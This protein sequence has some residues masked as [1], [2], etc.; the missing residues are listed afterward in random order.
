MVWPAD[1]RSAD[2]R[3]Y[4]S[5]ERLAEK[6]EAG[7]PILTRADLKKERPGIVPRGTIPGRFS[8]R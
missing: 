7:D 2:D 8:Q 5:A 1:D 3:L 4:G 6:M